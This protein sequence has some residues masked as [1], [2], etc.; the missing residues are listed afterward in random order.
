MVDELPDE[1]LRLIE[2]PADDL[3]R[4]R[5]DEE[6]F[7]SVRCSLDESAQGTAER[8]VSVGE[9]S[10]EG[11]EETKRRRGRGGGGAVAYL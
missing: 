2:V 6:G 10:A 8:R 1:F 7:F 3:F 11:A 4:V 5:G 9:W